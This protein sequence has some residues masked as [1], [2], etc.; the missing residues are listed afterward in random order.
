MRARRHDAAGGGGDVRRVQPA[1]LPHRGLCARIDPLHRHRA[2]AGAAAAVR[3][4]SGAVPATAG[5]LSANMLINS[6][7]RPTHFRRA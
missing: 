2:A 4:R 1:R 7:S 6:H 3:A 5:V